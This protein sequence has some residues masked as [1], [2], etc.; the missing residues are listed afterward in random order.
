M[1]DQNYT[2]ISCEL[3]SQYELA[4]MHKNSLL[5]QWQ[6]ENSLSHEAKVTP[7]DVITRNR[8]EYLKVLDS[9]GKENLIRLDR[10]SKMRIL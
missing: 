5:L 4:I 7:L 3:H 9:E 10:I 6:D 1:N 8:A 2:P